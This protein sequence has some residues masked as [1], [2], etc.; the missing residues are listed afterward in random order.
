MH[1][2]LLSL[3][4]ACASFLINPCVQDCHWE[5]CALSGHAHLCSFVC[6]SLAIWPLS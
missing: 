2:S 6:K 4:E 5:L 1:C 3:Q